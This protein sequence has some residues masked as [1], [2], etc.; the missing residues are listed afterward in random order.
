VLL[1]EFIGRREMIEQKKIAEIRA[2]LVKFIC[3]CCNEQTTYKC[4]ELNNAHC[5]YLD[6][7]QQAIL[8]LI[9]EEQKD[10]E[11]EL[12][13]AYMMGAEDM[14]ARQPKKPA[15]CPECGHPVHKDRCTE[16]VPLERYNDRDLFD[17]RSCGCTPADLKPAEPAYIAKTN[18]K[19]GEY[20]ELE[21][22]EP[23]RISICEDCKMQIV[24]AIKSLGK[25][26]CDLY[27]QETKAEPQPEM[28][29]IKVDPH[30]YECPSD[31][32]IGAD[33]Q[34]DADMAWH[35]EK[36]Q[37]VRKAFAETIISEITRG[38]FDNDSGDLLEPEL[39]AHIRAMA[40]VGS[41]D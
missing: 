4:N 16:L 2:I 9:T 30:S 36:V 11:G 28:P 8:A 41:N 10:R 7:A 22:A 23:H 25:K 31:V 38:N 35:K 13:V 18:A 14:K 27:M 33:R 19:K 26:E 5:K 12:T 17:Y 40:E 20:V 15:T 21:P 24:C 32:E 39:I 1:K 6:E 3:P 29:L 37:Q 34:R